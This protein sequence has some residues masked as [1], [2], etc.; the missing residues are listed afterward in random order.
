MADKTLACNTPTT[1]D[2]KA[3]GSGADR[4]EDEAMSKAWKSAHFFAVTRAL[5]EAAKLK[6][7]KECGKKKIMSA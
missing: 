2:K 5:Q 7:P 4:S 1:I 6:C 3:D